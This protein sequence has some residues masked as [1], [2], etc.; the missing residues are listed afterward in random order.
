MARRYVGNTIPKT[1]QEMAE[2]LTDPKL[3]AELLGGTENGWRDFHDAYAANMARD[4]SLDERIAEQVQ[5]GMAQFLRGDAGAAK[6]LNLSPGSASARNALHNKR[7]PG[8]ALD[9][10]FDSIGEFLQTVS[11]KADPTNPKLAELRTIQASMGS[12]VPADGGFLIPEQFRSEILMNS[13]ESSIVRP[14][15]TVVP[16]SSL[17]LSLPTVDETSHASSV[18]GGI[19][20]HWTEESAQLTATEPQ[21]GRTQLQSKKLTAFSNVPNELMRDAPGLDAFIRTAFPSA[22]SF[23]EDIAFLGG[24]GVGEPLG[25]L[26]GTGVVTVAKEAGQAADTVVYENFARMY[27]RMLPGS[28]SRAV[29]VASNDTFFE[30]ATMALNVGLGGV[31]AWIGWGDGIAGSPPMTVFGRPL[32][33]TEKVP[34]LGD[35]GD[36]SF[37]DFAYYLL[38]DRQQ[39]AIESSEHFR[40]QHDETSFRII[41]RCDGQPWLNSALTPYNGGATLSP[42]VKLEAR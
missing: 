3:A 36:V 17:T 5:A 22:V 42:Y 14:R 16:M 8:A 10:K 33:F 7:A 26:N 24:T 18:M 28:L 29:W 25:V 35:A 9:G 32:I 37:I 21:F 19:V 41:E 2:V 12:T 13:L 34:K 6:R 23:F 39:L 27:S 1:P 31:P 11:S 40:F 20:A 15:A 4:G 38:G 30:L